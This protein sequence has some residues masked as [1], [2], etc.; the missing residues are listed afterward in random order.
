MKFA[1]I[2]FLSLRRKNTFP[3]FHA[4]KRKKPS[5]AKLLYDIVVDKDFPGKIVI[6][7]GLLRAPAHFHSSSIVEGLLR[8]QSLLL[9]RHDV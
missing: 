7:E 3:S 1:Y 5:I 6:A 2:P 8:A 9:M 4:S